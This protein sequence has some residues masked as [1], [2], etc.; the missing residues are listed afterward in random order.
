M[1]FHT[2]SLH[3]YYIFRKTISVHG[4]I[5]EVGALTRNTQLVRQGGRLAKRKQ[6]REQVGKKC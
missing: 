1:R 3:A 2:L 4:G 6:M 5:Y